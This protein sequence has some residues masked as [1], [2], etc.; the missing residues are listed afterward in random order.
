[1][2][3]KQIHIDNPVKVN[4]ILQIEFYILQPYAGEAGIL[5]HWERKFTIIKLVI[6]FSC[7]VGF[8]VFIL[9]VILR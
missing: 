4:K 2:V 1:L 9:E 7:L 6:E 3:D 8:I 5:I